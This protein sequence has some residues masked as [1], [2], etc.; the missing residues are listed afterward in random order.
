MTDAGANPTSTAHP[1]IPDISRY[2]DETR[3][4]ALSRISISLAFCEP[5]PFSLVC[6]VLKLVSICIVQPVAVGAQIEQ[7]ERTMDAFF[8]LIFD[9]KLTL[10]YI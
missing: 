9:I 1:R 7:H 10:E 3:D 5:C 6:G 4:A 8:S 2:F